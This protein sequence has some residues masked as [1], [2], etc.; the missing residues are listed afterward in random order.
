MSL[1]EPFFFWCVTYCNSISF[2]FFHKQLSLLTA[3]YDQFQLV[4]P[5]FAPFFV[6]VDNGTE[7]VV[8]PFKDLDSLIDLS[9]NVSCLS[10]VWS[11]LL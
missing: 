10:V 7:F 4:Q 6:V 9:Q 1:S 11:D 3:A 2:V 5:S 8:K